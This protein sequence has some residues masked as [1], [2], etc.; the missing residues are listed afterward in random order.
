MTFGEMGVT[1]GEEGQVMT[2]REVVVIT[3]GGGKVVTIGEVEGITIG[4]GQVMSVRE[5]EV[6]TEGGGGR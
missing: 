3:E 5:V 2:V 1:T 4:E 6:I